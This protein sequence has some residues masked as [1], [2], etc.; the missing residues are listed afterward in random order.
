MT[1]IRILSLTLFFVLMLT[2]QVIAQPGAGSLVQHEGQLVQD[3]SSHRWKLKR[4]RPGRGVEE[5]LHELP[6]GDIETSV[7][8]P[9]KVPG[10]VYTDLWKAGVLEDPY[11]GRNSVKAQWVMQD[12]WWYSLQFNVSQAVDNKIVRIEF[13]GVDYSCE[14]WLNGHYLGSHEG[15][16]S[17]FSF[18]VT[19]LL[20][21]S[22]NWLHGRNILMVKLNPPPQVNHKVAGLKTPWFGDYWRD[23]VPFGI[24]RPVR[25]VST[26]QVRFDNV[27]VKS[28]LNDDGSADLDIEMT[29][30]NVAKDPREVAVNVTL[31]GH[32]FDCEPIHISGDRTIQPGKQTIHQAVTIAAPK[33]WWP[34]DLGD[35]N[36]YTAN[37]SI[38]DQASEL[39]R[40]STT[41]G[42]REVKMEWNPG[43]T[44]DEVSFPRTVMLNGKRHFIRSAC[45]GGP[46]DIFV[47]RTSTAEYKKLIEMAKDANMNNI[48]IFGWH[49][50]EI[51]EFYQYCNE[52]GITVWQDVIPLGTA[53][54]SQ[55]EAF[56]ERIY[57][58]A[59]AVI[60]E[61]RNHPCLI[62]IEGGE[63]AF[64]RASDAEFTKR[65]LDE[66]GRRL[67][68]HIDLPYV[69][70]SPLTCPV[71]QSVGYK[72]K[73]AVH[74]LAYFYSMGRWLM[75]DW[76]SELDFPI[77]PELAITSV[78]NVESLRKF[79]P[80]DEL[81]PPGPSWG[82]H[83][84]DLDR[85]RMQNYDTF[86]DERT[87]SLE[88]FV[89][90]TQDSQG[91][92]FQLSVEHFRRGKPR[93]SGIAL[94][95][96][97]TYWP[98]MKWG[99]VDN[100][101][102]PKRSYEFVKRAYQPL[103][104]SLQFD[105]RRWHAGESFAGK[106][107]IVN[108]RFESHENCQVE[109]S[110]CDDHDQVL[111][112]QT[113]PV[114]QIAPDSSAMITDIDWPIADSVD[115]VFHVK[116]KLIDSEDTTLS[117]NRYRLLIGDQ[118]EAREHMKQLGKKMHESVS[119]FTYD[120][121]YRFFPE[122]N[123]SDGKPSDSQTDVPRAA[124][125]D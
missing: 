87:G 47:G 119:K 56:I 31:E 120:N 113:I 35:P 61:R 91:T 21:T 112:T 84:A 121:Y 100:Y 125:F 94:C 99:I 105:R 53:N 45:W 69:P 2:A 4:M 75:E 9:A 5:G 18:D 117:T 34:W 79:I 38:T 88:E 13:D 78:P 62:L 30:E 110:F 3:L 8:I 64:L 77:V 24:W 7:W 40:T 66:L 46:P 67:Q 111:A 6:S 14:V 63:E 42:I 29:V 55:D 76:Y 33:L 116:L 32:N 70:D 96:Y 65:F 25:L 58:E 124:G 16:F 27:Y 54:L 59:V 93:V 51:P 10:D 92:I 81:W 86:G 22:S 108:D 103:L 11:F 89:N 49:P 90:A 20:H 17:P 97:I 52:A 48:R 104:V 1:V 109:L 73:E 15:M 28:K 43:F 50:P 106:L 12:E 101:Q 80:E 72:P 118:A 122:L 98:D 83:W 36:L 23:L 41:F 114:D 107:W 26:G 115:A 82:H 68:Q 102:Q 44:K 57:E 74:A 71:S 95:H 123:D 39:D 37:V 60:R 19:E 85:L